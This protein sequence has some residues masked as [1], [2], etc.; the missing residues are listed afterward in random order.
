M[1]ILS[2][3]TEMPLI[4]GKVGVSKKNCFYLSDGFDTLFCLMLVLEV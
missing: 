4:S 2:Q 3:S 1:K